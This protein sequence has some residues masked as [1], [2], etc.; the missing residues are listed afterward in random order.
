MT[1][2]EA[3][4]IIL[5]AQSQPREIELWKLAFASQ[6]FKIIDTLPDQQLLQ[7][8][9]VNHDV[10]LL[11]LDI[12]TKSFNPYL[13]C[14]KILKSY[15]DLSIILTDHQRQ[16]ISDAEYKLAISQ[17]A[18]DV[19]P[20]LVKNSELTVVLK[21]MFQVVGWN[22]FFDREAL[23]KSLGLQRRQRQEFNSS[24]TKTVPKGNQFIDRN[25]FPSSPRSTYERE[26]LEMNNQSWETQRRKDL[27]LDKK[28]VT[29]TS[30]SLRTEE[31]IK[32][33]Y[34]Q[35]A[36]QIQ[37][38]GKHT[39]PFQQQENKVFP[40]ITCIDDTHAVHRQ[41]K[42]TL[43]SVGYRVVCITKPAS[44]LSTLVQQKPALILMDINMPELN[45]YEL[46][47]MLQR[48]RKLRDIPIVMLTA[49]QGIIN[50]FRAKYVGAIRYLKKPFEPDRL[51]AVVDEIV[52]SKLFT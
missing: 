3:H 26:Q 13:F 29:R 31:K 6:G 36:T 22:A 2:S 51:I 35:R 14:R 28:P 23:E 41:V 34:A 20:R 44:A 38:L 5:V 7:T 46:C 39:L 12:T 15:P 27:W 48:S 49:E 24:Q 18:K 33:N 19:I 10:R 1:M 42:K 16:K 43:E 52:K 11:L 30:F 47:E 17:G 4:K 45:G 40:L 32:N 21:K 8:N 9:I 37:P 50:R 25:I